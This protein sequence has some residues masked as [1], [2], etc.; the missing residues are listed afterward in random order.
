MTGATTENSFMCTQFR[1]CLFVISLYFGFGGGFGVHFGAYLGFGGV[2]YF[3]WGA[4]DRK[5]WQKATKKSDRSIR[6]S[7]QRTERVPKKKKVIELLLPT[8]LSGGVQSTD[9]SQ[10]VRETGRDES[11]SVLSPERNSSKQGIWSS[12][13]SRDM[14]QVVGRAPRDTPVHMYSVTKKKK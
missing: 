3:V 2:L 6:K 1:M 11:Q 14:S 9:V 10:I 5:V 7:D 12:H 8:S 13:F 4:Y